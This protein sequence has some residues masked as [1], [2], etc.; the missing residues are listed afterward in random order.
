M[1]VLS[2]LQRNSSITF[3][4]HDAVYLY[5]RVLNQSLAEGYTDF[6]DGRS[7]RNKAVGQEFDGMSDLFCHVSCKRHYDVTDAKIMF[8]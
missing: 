6:S 3:F 7:I 5:L 4:L 8:A 1:C 2:M